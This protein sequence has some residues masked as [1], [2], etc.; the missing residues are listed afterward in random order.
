MNEPEPMAYIGFKPCGCVMFVAA[1]LPELAK[2]IAECV[3]ET[4]E[5]GGRVERVTCETVRQTAFICP[6]H[7]AENEAKKTQLVMAL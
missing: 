4:V 1:E 5:D 2:D 7:K 6:K 3:A